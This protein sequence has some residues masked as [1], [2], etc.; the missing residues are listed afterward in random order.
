VIG[1]PSGKYGLG[2]KMERF[3]VVGLGVSPL[4]MVTLVDHF[5]AEEG[6]QMALDIA[7]QGGGPVATA[8]VT[9]AR[10]G[11]KTAMLDAIA[12]DWRGKLVLAEF[13]AEGVCTDYLK[14]SPGRISSTATVLVSRQA[15]GARAIVFYP[16]TAPELSP[17]DLPRPEIESARFLHVNGRHWEACLEACRWARTAGVPVSFDG[18][19]HRYRPE[20]RQLVPLTDVCIVARDFA[21]K[22]TQA[23]DIRQ[24]AEALLREGPRLVA[25]TDGVRGSWVRSREGEFFHQPAY[26]LPDVVDTTGC[27]DSYHGAFLFGL[28]QGWELKRAAALASAVAALNSRHLG[29]RGGLPTLEQA[30]AFL[31]GVSC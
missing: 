3:D 30:E 18:G 26:L 7:V 22:Y 15:G 5:P 11:A 19:A 2:L 31:A 24:A 16:G 4:D 12:D 10:L 25:I 9:L 14:V 20:L 8:L 1:L 17:A 21:E 29:G 27:G 13:R 23:A 6:V 28:L